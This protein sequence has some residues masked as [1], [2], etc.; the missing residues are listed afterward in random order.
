MRQIVVGVDGSAVSRRALRWAAEEAQ[1]SEASLRV[2]MAEENLGRDTWMPTAPQDERLA[3]PRRRL[4]RLVK[5]VAAGFPKVAIEPLVLEGPAAK[6]LVEAARDADLLVV[7]SRGRGGFSGVLLGS[8]S[9]HC[10]SHATCP[11]VVVR[12]RPRSEE[13]EG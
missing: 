12:G 10:V 7:G 2:V 6:V 11:V 3:L 5:G 9:F 1:L 13:S 8:V 4:S